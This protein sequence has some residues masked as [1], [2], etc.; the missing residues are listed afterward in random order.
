MERSLDSQIVF[1]IIK[2]LFISTMYDFKYDAYRKK[3]VGHRIA[4]QNVSSTPRH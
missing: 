1:L 2:K 3:K 4:V